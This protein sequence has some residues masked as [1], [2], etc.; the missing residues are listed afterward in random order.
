[1]SLDE[2]EK[3]LD[4]FSCQGHELSLA[5]KQALRRVQPKRSEFPDDFFGSTHRSA[6]AVLE[7]IKS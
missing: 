4:G 6:D 3:D 7:L 2:Q 1:M 5:E